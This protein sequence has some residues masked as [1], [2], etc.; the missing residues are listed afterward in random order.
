MECVEKGGL[1]ICWDESRDKAIRLEQPRNPNAHFYELEVPKQLWMPMSPYAGKCIKSMGT[2]F[3]GRD[4]G[5]FKVVYMVRDREAQAT[6]VKFAC[7]QVTST[8]KQKKL[9]KTFIE[10]LRKSN[11]VDSLIILDYDEVLKNP[12]KAFRSLE[13][14]GWPI[15]PVKAASGVKPNLKHY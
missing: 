3:L 2:M 9:N 5:P 13:D 1:E 8:E 11:Q 12:Q 4:G 15:D 7:G 10:R 14:D 6:S